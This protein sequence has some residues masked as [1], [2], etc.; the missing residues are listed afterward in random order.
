MKKVR[1]EE[2]S[3]YISHS[4]VQNA[5]CLCNLWRKKIINCILSVWSITLLETMWWR[6]QARYILKYVNQLQIFLTVIKASKKYF[7]L[8]TL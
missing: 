4:T 8:N 3:G 1:L 5:F 7:I 6:C 2:S